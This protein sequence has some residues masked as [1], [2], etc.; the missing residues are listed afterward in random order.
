MMF[1][2]ITALGLAAL[3]AACGWRRTPVPVIAELGS[4]ALIVGTWSGDY[5]SSETGRAGSITF[6]MASE[7]DTAFC[8]VS[9]IPRFQSVRMTQENSGPA[10]ARPAPPAEPL[11]VRFI[12]LGDGKVTGTM[13]PYVDPDCSCRV[14][15]T[16]LGRFAGPNTIEGTYRSVPVGSGGIATTGTWKVVRDKTRPAQR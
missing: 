1:S 9:M 4:E 11:K 12:R 3:L 10:I 16:F 15:T 14:T 5:H 13:E 6:D 7:K 2:R 8:D